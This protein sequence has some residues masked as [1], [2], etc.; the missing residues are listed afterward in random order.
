MSE[1]CMFCRKDGATSRLSLTINKGGV[2]R[3]EYFNLCTYCVREAIEDLKLLRDE[4]R[5]R[6]DDGEDDDGPEAA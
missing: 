1:V 3:D 2:T 6:V 5:G 4:I